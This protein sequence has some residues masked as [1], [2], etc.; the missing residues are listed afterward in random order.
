MRRT[1]SEV[2]RD[3]EIRIARLERQSALNDPFVTITSSLGRRD[4]HVLAENL[5]FN[6]NDVAYVSDPDLLASDLME[7]PKL[8]L[9]A[10]ID[11][12]VA[13]MSYGGMSG[14]RDQYGE[15][16]YDELDDMVAQSATAKLKKLQRAKLDIKQVVSPRTGTNGWVLTLK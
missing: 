8:I 10:L 6:K 4:A 15:V 7:H 2:I 12:A 1:A 11:I 5:T 14:M 16:M 3:L 13:R 9:N